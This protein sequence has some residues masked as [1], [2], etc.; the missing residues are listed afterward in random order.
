MTLFPKLFL[1]LFTAKPAN[2]TQHLRPA[3]TYGPL[4]QFFLPVCNGKAVASN[5]RNRFILVVQRRC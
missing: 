4:F 1:N 2:A 5:A 3:L